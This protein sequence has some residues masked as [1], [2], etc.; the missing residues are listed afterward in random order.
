MQQLLDAGSRVEA[1]AMRIAPARP[2][3]APASS[4]ETL[5]LQM[6]D[7]LARIETLIEQW[8]ARPS[9]LSRDDHERLARVL[10]AVAGA[11]G[12]E[13]F[14]ARELVEHAAAAVRIV[15]TGLTARQLGRLLK[16][17]EG[18]NGGGYTVQRQGSEVGSILWRVLATTR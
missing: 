6:L 13:L 17:A 10:P 12:S 14:T 7:R 8:Q 15:V 9:T 11:L 2:G 1:P 3:V 18:A 5:L 4:T 16:R